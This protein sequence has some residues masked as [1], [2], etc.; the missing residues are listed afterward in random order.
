MKILTLVARILLGLAFLVFGL[1]GI[2]N[3]IPVPPIP[4]GLMKDF[5]TVMATSHYMA[6]VG[7]FEVVAAILFLINRY[8]PLALVLIGPV[9]VN[10]LIFHILIAP[11]SIG[12]GIFVTICWF[13]VFRSVRGAF[14]GIFQAKA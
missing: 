10:I 1:N 6:A 2:F 3:F 9:I 14:A 7:I 4:P 11:A 8:V 12:P 5:S 13:I